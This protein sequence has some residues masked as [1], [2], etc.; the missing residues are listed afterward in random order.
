MPTMSA[1]R[2]GL[3]PHHTARQHT[4][5]TEQVAVIHITSYKNQV[6]QKK[7]HLWNTNLRPGLCLH[8]GMP[9][10]EVVRYRRLADTQARLHLHL[11]LQLSMHVLANLPALFEHDVYYTMLHACAHPC[12]QCWHGHA[13]Q[14][15]DQRP[16]ADHQDGVDANTFCGNFSPEAGGQACWWTSRG[17]SSHR[18]CRGGQSHTLSQLLS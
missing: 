8:R 11:H 12:P 17:R 2:L 14:G 15:L 6:F 9:T 4:L 5:L 1:T 7:A 16:P 3:R 18:C 13:G 10:S